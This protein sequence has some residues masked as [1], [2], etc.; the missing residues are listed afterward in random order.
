MR[1]LKIV[2]A[3]TGLF[4]ALSCWADSSQKPWFSDG[5]I[6]KISKTFEKFLKTWYV[7]RDEAHFWGFMSRFSKVWPANIFKGVFSKKDAKSQPTKLEIHTGYIPQQLEELGLG[8]LNKNSQDRYCIVNG[9]SAVAFLKYLYEDKREVREPSFTRF[10]FIVYIVEGEGI[11]KKGM[12]TIWINEPGQ[13]WKI[14]SIEEF[15]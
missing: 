1:S 5:D 8:C 3:A 6:R 15:S 11:N 10:F 9:E 14:W 2:V 12:L 4:L 7:E 13:G